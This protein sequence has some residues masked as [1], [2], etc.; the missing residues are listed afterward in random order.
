MNLAFEQATVISDSFANAGEM[1]WLNVTSVGGRMVDMVLANVAGNHLDSCSGTSSDGSE[2]PCTGGRR[3]GFAF[4]RFQCR[5]PLDQLLFRFEFHGSSEPA[6]LAGFDLTVGDL[7]RA[8]TFSVHSIDLS[9]YTFG[10]Q[11]QVSQSAANGFTEFRTVGGTAPNVAGSIGNFESPASMTSQ[12]LQWMARLFFAN[13]SQF[14]ARLGCTSSYSGAGG[15][16]RKVFF[17]GHTD[18]GNDRCPPPSPPAP[19]PLPPSPPV[20]P[21]SPLSACAAYPYTARNATLLTELWVRPGL[22]PNIGPTSRWFGGGGTTADM[23]RC[24]AAAQHGGRG[25]LRGTYSFYTDEEGRQEVAAPL[26]FFAFRHIPD[27]FLGYMCVFGSLPAGETVATVRA[28]DQSSEDVLFDMSTVFSSVPIQFGQPLSSPSSTSPPPSPPLPSP[29]LG[30]LTACKDFHT[31]PVSWLQ[32]SGNSAFQEGSWDYGCELGYYGTASAAPDCASVTPAGGACGQ[33]GYTRIH[34]S[35]CSGGGCCTAS[36]NIAEAGCAAFFNHHPPPPSLSPPPTPPP[37]PPSSSSPPPTPPASS[38]SPPPPPPTH[39]PLHCIDECSSHYSFPTPLLPKSRNRGF[40]RDSWEIG[41]RHS[42]ATT[43]AADCRQSCSSPQGCCTT[44]CRSNSCSGGGCCRASRD[45]CQQACDLYYGACT[46]SQWAFASLPPPPPPVPPPRPPPPPRF[47]HDLINH[48]QQAAEAALTLAANNQTSSSIA[49]ASSALQLA[50]QALSAA[51]TEVPSERPP[52]SSDSLVNPSLEEIAT[53]TL[54]V[55]G[56]ALDAV[57]RG[58]GPS[59][60][61]FTRDLAIAIEPHIEAGA[62]P[63]ILLSPSLA[64]AVVSPYAGDMPTVAGAPF[65]VAPHDALPAHGVSV[66]LSV[67]SAENDGQYEWLVA[68]PPEL[69]TK[70]GAAVAVFA[71]DPYGWDGATDVRT[72][73]FSTGVVSVR[74]LDHA[75]D[76]VGP[77]RRLSSA[78]EGL[79]AFNA[80]SLP[81]RGGANCTS[82]AVSS[83]VLGWGVEGDEECPGGYCCDGKCMCDQGF[84]GERCEVHVACGHVPLNASAWDTSTCALLMPDANASAWLRC[85][86]TATEGEFTLLADRV[87]SRWLPPSNVRLNSEVFVRLGVRL[88]ERPGGYILALSILLVWATI[89]WIALRSDARCVYV[90]SVPQWMW[91]TDRYS[92]RWRFQY[93]L[94]RRHTLVASC[95]VVPGHSRFAHVQIVT[96]LFNEMLIEFTCC[97]MW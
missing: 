62:P 3:G 11:I 83:L 52:T 59:V 12:Q 78:S 90:R 92:L 85:R 53:A 95:Y 36:H 49:A 91:A 43:S 58:I 75:A 44:T 86:C 21:S 72:K 15:C 56:S 4:I 65:S 37:S 8:E 7:E 26:Q 89:S 1:R 94:R 68:L 73:P 20:P 51:L 84:Y 80:S 10:S 60:L 63:L 54:A 14:R 27:P 69:R 5:A 22:H 2:R 23:E 24:C 81:Q 87:A 18:L 9:Y 50:R 45:I 34:S 46:D 35:A 61:A 32:K 66:A 39:P 29:P 30:P 71:T 64:L 57:G 97:V 88:R 82:A 93:H 47:P 48:A 67:S 31:F 76:L 28:W 40:Q 16:C 55:A 25:P 77:D 19:P 96:T 42:A 38:P 6:V 79:L 41:C 17:A 70:G 13:T 33:P 74:R